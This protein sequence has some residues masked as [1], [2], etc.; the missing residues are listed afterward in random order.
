[1]TAPAG[2]AWTGVSNNTSWLTVTSGASG[3]G[4]GTV[5]FSASANPTTSARTGTITIGGQTFTVNQAAAACTYALRRRA[6]RSSRVAARGSTTVTAPAGCAWTGVSNNTSWLTVTS[7][8]SG[9]GTGTVAFSAS[10]N[11][12]TSARTGTIT[13]GGQTF[14][15][16]QA[17]AAC[18][19]TLRRRASRSSRGAARG[20]TT[21]TAPAG[22]AW[23]GVS[24]NTSWLTV[25][26]G[27]SG[28][29][30]GTVAFSASANPNTS[31]AHRDDHDRGPD[32]HRQPGGRAVH[33][34][35]LADEPVGRRGRRHAGQRRVT[36]PAGCAWTGVSNNTSWLTVTSGASGSGTGTRGVQCVGQSEHERRAPGRSRS[37]ARRSPSTR[38]P[39]P[40]P[41]RCSR[42]ASRSSPAAARG[43]TTVT[44]PAGCAWTGVEQQ[45]VVADGDE[46]GER[47]RD[48]HAWRSV[49]R[50]IRIRARALGRSRSRARRSA[51][52]RRPPPA[53]TRCCRRAS[54]SSR[55]A[56]RGQQRV[57][58]L[59]GCAW[60]G[61][62]NNTAWLT[63]TSGASGS[64]TGTVA[65][66]ASA[67]P[68]TSAA[69]WDAH[70][71]GP[72]VH[73]QPGG[74]RLHLHAAP[75]SQ[76]VVAGGGT[77]VDGA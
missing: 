54:R 74:R 42:R 15:V 20:S 34:R 71:R 22:C 5:A 43:S 6:N 57:T 70:D 61:V 73:R 19:Y 67:N 55:V 52:T 3:S 16:N 40:A 77:R 45:H 56:A 58:A 46:R 41:T 48:R 12:N 75:T 76:S 1:M 47:Q 27:A 39:P 64:G 31:A 28:S 66:S 25:T 14:T 53:P 13:I 10:A 60:T 30:T 50:P 2:C 65:F 69:H 59:A 32:V 29:G 9:S 62:S 8:A 4:T 68:N 18:T 17:A 24:N 21:V 37:G 51:S 49:R 35:A 11:P 63:V 23:T 72:D 33:L 7:G 26:S 36:A 38:R 44:A